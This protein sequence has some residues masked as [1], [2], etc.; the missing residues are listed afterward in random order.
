MAAVASRVRLPGTVIT[1]G[2]VSR[3]VTAKVAAEALPCES[4]ALHATVV[5][6]SG[7][8][9][10]LAGVQA[11]ATAPSTSSSADAEKLY[12]AP[13][14]PAAETLA[15]AGTVITGC[16][17][18]LTV[19]RNDADPVLPCASVALHWT[20]VVPNGNVAPAAGVQVAA[21]TPSTLSSADAE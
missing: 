17:V 18:S 5:V 6:P 16:V 13:A 2:V 12:E 19:T 3:T 21:S 10:P 4:V 11:T 15:L 9:L 8:M 14:A 7:K 20:I 1:G